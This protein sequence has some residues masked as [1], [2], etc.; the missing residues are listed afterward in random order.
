MTHWLLVIFILGTGDFGL[1]QVS[2]EAE[3]R[4]QAA[5]VK[6]KAPVAV[7]TACYRRADVL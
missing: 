3:C 1:M 5:V 2:S 4:Q 6:A 7:E